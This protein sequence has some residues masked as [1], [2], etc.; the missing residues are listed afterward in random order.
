MKHELLVP[1]GNYDCLIAAINNGADAVYLAGKKYGAR[2]FADNFSLE[3]LEEVIKLCHLYGV[4]I[5]ITVNT[6]MFDNEIDDCINYIKAIHEYGVDALIMQDIGLINVVHN[7]FPNLEIHASTQMHNHSEESMKFLESL[8]IKRV[9]FARELDIDTINNINTT[10]EKEAFIHGSLCISYSG[11]CYF[12]KEILDR[13]ANRGQCAGMCRLKYD[14]LREDEVLNSGYLLSPKDL[15]TINEFDKLMKSNIVSFKIEGRM[16]SPLYVATV[17][18][19]YRTLIDN[20]ENNNKLAINN[21]DYDLLKSIFYREYTKGLLFNDNNII[22]SKSS[23]HIG[24]LIGKVLEITKKRIK[25]KLNKSVRQGEGIRFKESDKGINLNFI[26]DKNDNLISSAS[27]GD[28]VYIDNFINLQ[29]LDT[30]YLTNPLNELDSEI[31]KKIEINIKYKAKLGDDFELIISDGE[32]EI[33]LNSNIISKAKNSPVDKDS[34]NKV[35]SKVGNTPFKINNITGKLD[36]DLFI[37]IGDLN[38][39]RR[40]ALDKLKELRENKKVNVIYRN[41]ERDIPNNKPVSGISV[42]ARTSE[43]VKALKT[44]KVRIIVDKSELYEDGF[45]FKVP[46]NSLKYDYNY[47]NYLNTTYPSSNKYNKGIGDYFL[48]ITNH[49]SLDLMLKHNDIV[50]LSPEN[51]ILDIKEII[52]NYKEKV[53]AEVYIYGNIE[54]MMMK[55]CIIK[56]SLNNSTCGLCMNKN[57]YYLKDRNGEKYRIITDV[58]SHTSYLLNY[59]KTNLINDIPTLKNIGINNFRIDLLDEN[60]DETIE[61][62]NM[63][64]NKIIC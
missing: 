27:S 29:S 5:Y 14:I 26:Y 37:R 13:S 44:L 61:L 10:M 33:T 62:I 6:L 15:C 20:Y 52:S 21:E 48:N 19:I 12:S 11:Q 30:V 18:R 47:S 56:S 31:T 4:K 28:I 42:L 64:K 59:K 9:V 24:L 25:I 40:E 36:E 39:L 23:N 1:V 3:K 32:N 34:I 55:S 60:Y 54:L 41:Y 50:T 22:N 38:N 58:K 35:L 46:R 57:K 51:T 63:I 17:T 16:K 7:M 2:A 8:G 43:Q 53:N 49:H 45:Y